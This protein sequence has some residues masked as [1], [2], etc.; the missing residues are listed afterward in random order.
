MPRRPIKKHQRGVSLFVLQWLVL[1]ALRYVQW[2]LSSK[3]CTKVHPHLD[4]LSRKYLKLWEAARLGRSKALPVRHQHSLSEYW[5]A[6]PGDPQAPAD[7]WPLGRYAARG[8]I[9][10]V[11]LGYRFP[12]YRQAPV[13]SAPKRADARLAR[14]RAPK[15]NDFHSALP[16]NEQFQ[17]RIGA[18]INKGEHA[19]WIPLCGKRGPDSAPL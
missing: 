8:G 10:Q 5:P 15:Q 7:P 14:I 4:S 6:R 13:V 11:G 3:S 18:Q 12:L 1:R 16:V 9:A 2:N 19:A 17:R